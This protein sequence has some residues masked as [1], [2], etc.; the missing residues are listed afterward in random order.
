MWASGEDFIYSSSSLKIN[1]DNSIYAITGVS[2]GNA[3]IT[4]VHKVTES[5]KTLLLQYL[6][7][8]YLKQ[9]DDLGLNPMVL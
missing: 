9:E 5:V 6:H 3:S 8:N 1:I 7:L 4:A 2:V